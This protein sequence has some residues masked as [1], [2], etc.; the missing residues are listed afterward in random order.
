MITIPITTVPIVVLLL[1]IFFLY[2]YYFVIFFSLSRR[3]QMHLP[4]L[5]P[6]HAIPDASLTSLAPP[7]LTSHDLG[8]AHARSLEWAFMKVVITFALDLAFK[9]LRST[10]VDLIVTAV[11]PFFRNLAKGQ[12][13]EEPSPGAGSGFSQVA[14]HVLTGIVAFLQDP[15][16]DK[17]DFGVKGGGG[18]SADQYLPKDVKTE[19]PLADEGENLT[20]SDG[21][22]NGLHSNL[23]ENG[24]SI[25]GETTLNI[26]SDTRLQFQDLSN[27]DNEVFDLTKDDRG[28]D[29]V[30]NEITISDNNNLTRELDSGI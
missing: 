22:E 6:P 11:F 9:S 30:E 13:I 14:S 20:V 12:R 28:T 21:I 15:A 7:T 17:L 25:E 27:T 19:S 18:G 10:L 2:L 26:D 23:S 24:G 8:H 4:A 3:P 29:E 16:E 5:Y 1:H